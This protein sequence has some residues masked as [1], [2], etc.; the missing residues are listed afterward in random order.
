MHHQLADIKFYYFF[1]R[2]FTV[3]GPRSVQFGKNY[4]VLLTTTEYYDD[5]SDGDIIVTMEGAMTGVEIGEYSIP[6]G[7]VEQQLTFDVSRNKSFKLK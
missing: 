5:D 3:I 1:L 4:S 7:S 2:H 6:L